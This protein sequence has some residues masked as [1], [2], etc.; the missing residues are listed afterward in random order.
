MASA[1]EIALDVLRSFGPNVVSR[2]SPMTYGQY[3]ASIG[4]NP[5]DYG[6][7]V[8]M[9]M[10]AIGA[11]CIIRQVPVAPLF[12]VQSANGEAQ[13]I[14]ETDP[15]ERR[16]I[17][18][19]KDIDTMYVVAREYRYSISEFEG[20]EAALRKSL[21]S[22]KVTKWSPHQLWHLTFQKAPKDSAVT[23]YQ[24]AMNRYH[25]LFIQIKARKATDQPS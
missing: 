22:G 6:L 8:G 25:E 24:R 12:W 10:H 4:R 14:F 17:I 13:S 18:D 1:Q 3:A 7:A 15:I 20:I 19:T 5:A 23:Y 9:A 2:G 16:H 21:A 11:L